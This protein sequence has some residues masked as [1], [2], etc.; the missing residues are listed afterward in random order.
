MA[1]A[2]RLLPA[3][4]LAAVTTAGCGSMQ[5]SASSSA[6]RVPT[7]SNVRV[8]D[9]PPA[10]GSRSWAQPTLSRARHGYVATLRPGGAGA[11]STAARPVKVRLTG[12]GYPSRSTASGTAIVGPGV[13]APWTQIAHGQ[14][15]VSVAHRGRWL[16]LRIWSR[17]GRWRAKVDGRYV[18]PTPRRVGSDY[19]LHTIGLRFARAT[20]RHVV[21]FELSGGAW[22]AGVLATGGD[23]LALPP[24]PKGPSAY[25]LGDSY[26]AGGGSRHPGFSDLVHTASARLGYQ[27][28]TVDALGGTGYVR[29]NQSAH[30]ED[31]LTR[32]RTNLRAGRAQPDVIVVGGSINDIGEPPSRVATAARQLYAYLARAVP[33]AKVFVVVFAP[34]FPVPANFAAL[35]HAVLSAAAASPNVAGAFDLPARA[36]RAPRGLQGPDAHPTQAGHD[37]YGRL[38]AD[39]I[40]ARRR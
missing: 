38:I 9:A 12:I 6:V 28:V 39:F 26:F 19:A 33:R 11:A 36:A 29:D 16:G 24:R 37:A 25:W 31:Y 3:L 2:R 32:A 14:Y 40:R 20:K 34:R 8:A 18:D 21:Q 5:D 35:D 7:A 1:A 13:A 17:G 27:D 10:G 23:H 30:F 22:L 4:L 15:T